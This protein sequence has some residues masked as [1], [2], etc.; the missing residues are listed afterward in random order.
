ME[1]VRKWYRNRMAACG[2]DVETA[3]ALYRFPP[4]TRYLSELLGHVSRSLVFDL[5]IGERSFVAATRRVQ[6]LS[7][8]YLE[9]LY[10]KEC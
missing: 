10:C 3:V 5:G 8:R 2:K 1:R 9:D 4:R 7:P 6:D